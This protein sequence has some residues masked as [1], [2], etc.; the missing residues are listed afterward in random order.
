[1]S[2]ITEEG[3]RIIKFDYDREKYASVYEILHQI[4]LMPLP[5]YIT[6]QLRENDRYQTVY[7]REEGS[8]ILFTIVN[9]GL[10]NI[11]GSCI[12]Q[13]GEGA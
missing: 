5:P 11:A 13:S 8:A 7:A 1:M 9:A 12:V 3:N 4:G 10:V 6:E 2:S